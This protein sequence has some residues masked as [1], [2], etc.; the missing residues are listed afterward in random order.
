MAHGSE[1]FVL[2]Q[3][4]AGQLLVGTVELFRRLPHPL[5][6]VGALLC[7]GVVGRPELRLRALALRDVGNT[8][9]RAY[10]TAITVDGV[11]VVF[12]REAAA[13]RAPRHLVVDIDWRAVAGGAG[14]LAFLDRIGRAVR[15]GVMHGRMHVSPFQLGRRF[16]S[17]AVPRRYRSRRGARNALSKYAAAGRAESKT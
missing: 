7:Q 12:H 15:V 17:A 9:D 5:R 13:V 2:R 8:Y 10:E 16:V 14:G 6:Q 3:R 1:K 11:R 4:G